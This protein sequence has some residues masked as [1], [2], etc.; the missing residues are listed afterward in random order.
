MRQE[1]ISKQKAKE[2]NARQRGDSAAATRQYPAQSARIFGA[3]VLGLSLLGAASNAWG[4]TG[5]PGAPDPLMSS[6]NDAMQISAGQ[7][8]APGGS[9]AS[10]QNQSPF[11]QSVPSGP[12][13]PGIIKLSLID[14]IDRGLKQNLGLLLSNDSMTDVR[15]KRWQELS[16]LLPNVT[17]QIS[18]NLRQIDLAAEGLTFSPGIPL[19]IGPFGYV[20]A[21]AF[22]SQPI[23]DLH[24]LN[25]VRS[26]NQSIRAAQYTYKDA[27]DLVVLA[28]G[29]NYL[30][31]ISQVARVQTVNSQLDTAQALYRQAENQ[32][33]AGT[34]PEIDQL[35][36]QVEF[37]TRQQQLIAARNDLEKQKLALAR[38]IG[39]PLGQQFE[40]TDQVPY[41]KVTPST[42]DEELSRAYLG[43]ADYQSAEAQV[44]AAEYT[45]KA[46]RA[47]Y[48]PSAQFNADYGDI[49]TTFAHSHG[50]VDIAGSLQIP[51]FNGGKTH[52]DVL[53][54]EASLA[55][56]HQ[57]LES[58]RGQIDQDVRT[59]LFD[60]QS[61]AQQ[62][63]VAQSNIDLSNRTLKQAQDRFSAGV[64]NNIEVVQAQQSVASANESYISSLF[65]YDYAKLSLARAIGFA[66]QGVKQY[67]KGM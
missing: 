42:V 53:R 57:Q 32:L 46:A 33:K 14:A 55:Q 13:N 4:Q 26:A 47:E 27:R 19:I 64:T 49:G 24:A 10:G 59:A 40:I 39:L 54:A 36:A 37:Q 25:N 66:E 16:H 31:V 23:L 7:S 51:I 65:N 3:A 18:D 43:R 22:Y 44:H 6:T 35:R 15:G 12:A 20:D 5:A 41:K 1:S 52:G 9:S 58:L 28:V 21:R 38:V 62:V 48:L 61:A 8:S 45:L 56:A 34:S 60:V 50:T 17:T 30:Q 29:L 11:F 2:Q 67:L 63:E